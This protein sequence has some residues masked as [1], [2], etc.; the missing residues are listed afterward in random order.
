VRIATVLL[1][2]IAA[3]ADAQWL[4]LKEAIRAAGQNGQLILLQIRTEDRDDKHADEWMAKAMEHAAVKR[5]MASMNLARDRGERP[6]LV[7]LDQRGNEVLKP[8]SAF[9]NINQFA[10]TLASMN[11]HAPAFAASAELR[12]RGR[13]AEAELVRGNALLSSGEVLPAR[14]AFDIA[15]E[16]ARKEKNALAEQRAR[17]GMIS[18]DLNDSRFARAA[19]A[20][21]GLITH[22]PLAPD[23]AATAWILLGHDAKKKFQ[24]QQAIDA[25][26]HAWRAAEKPSELADVARNA[27][28]MM[29]VTPASDVAAAAA[30]GEV[31]LVFAKK[32]VMVGSLEVKASAPPSA[33]RVEFSLDGARVS[34]DTLPPFA[35]TI[36]LGAAPRVHTLA[37]RAFDAHNRVVGE[38]SA[39]INDVVDAL[40]VRV[41]APEAIESRATIVAEPRAPAGAKIEAVDVYWSDK[42]LATLTAPPYRYELTL[43]SKNAAGYVRVVARDSTGATAEDVKMV[44]VAGVAEE[45]RVDLVEINTV[46]HDRG[47]HN[48]EGLTSRDFAVKE[49]GTPV[50][51]EVR[52]TPNDPIA[53]GFALDTSSSMRALMIDVAEYAAAFVGG[54]LQSG[55]QAFVVGFTDKPRLVQP[56][57]GDLKHV[58]ASILDIDAAG[59]TSMWD[60]LIYSLQQLRPVKGKRALLLFTDGADTTSTAHY[61]TALA[62]AQE[63]GV[64]VY[65]FLMRADAGPPWTIL[66]IRRLGALADATGGAMFQSPRKSD[67]PRLFAQIRDDTRGEY[68][69]SFHSKSAR[70]HTELRTISVSVPG[71]DAVVRAMSGYYPR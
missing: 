19:Y 44:N 22:D 14:L 42:K 3:S 43:P 12:A 5:A 39:T 21:L 1:F 48:V 26:Q 60:S 59:G 30:T 8:D 11:H 35:A 55:D 37:A 6:S 16:H 28:E 46:V 70:P 67:L 25:Y 69:L 71:R 31:H 41:A 68:L 51:A 65:V 20:Q 57:T 62:V 66:D 32:P 17:L 63:V 50:A 9:R 18:I 64:P 27:L 2:T 47:G 61:D 33:S 24:R 36:Q 49:D 52:S 15:I 38:E 23:V 58:T 54:S 45:M 7:V 40:S 56:L 4:P 10:V 13:I 29:G 53:V 34:D